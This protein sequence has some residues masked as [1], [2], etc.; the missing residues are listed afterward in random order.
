M[1]CQCEVTPGDCFRFHSVGG[2]LHVFA[3]SG[4]MIS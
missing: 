3:A 2:Y 4:W 1:S